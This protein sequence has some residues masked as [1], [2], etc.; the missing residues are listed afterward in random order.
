MNKPIPAKDVVPAKVT[1]GPLP[2]SRKIYSSPPGHDE[3]KVPLREIALTDGASASSSEAVG[4]N[5]VFHVYDTSGPYTDA[6]AAID[7]ARG[8]PRMRAAWIEARRQDG[9]VTQLEFARAGIITKEMV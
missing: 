6:G 3:V 7:V 5:K 1:S 2:A 9:L 8:L 4:H